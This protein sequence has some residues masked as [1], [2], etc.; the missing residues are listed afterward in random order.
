MNCSFFL[1]FRWQSFFALHP[2][3]P[4][5]KLFLGNGA[6]NNSKSGAL[7]AFLMAF[8]VREDL[9]LKDLSTTSKWL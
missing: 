5:N 6:Y 8:N 9:F 2:I 1:Q 7:A 4:S 3:N